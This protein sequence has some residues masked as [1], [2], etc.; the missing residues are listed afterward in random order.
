MPDNIWFE[1]AIWMGLAFIASLISIRVGISVALI[2]IFVGIVAGNFLGI[3]QTTQWID[4]LAMLGSVVLTFLAG[5]EIDPK[6]LKANIKISSTIGILSFAIP[7]AFIWMFAQFV[8]GWDI[9]QAQIAG[10]ALSTTSVA[11]IYAVLIEKEL[12]DTSLGKMLLASCFITDL[13]TVLALGALFAELSRLLAVFAAV[14][15]LVLWLMPRC[16]KHIIGKFGAKRVSEPE[17]KFILLIL[18]FMGGLATTAKS[19]AVLP[20]Y[21]IGL[22][23]AG[24]FLTDKT[25]VNRMRTIAFTIFTP[26][27]FIKA[28]LYVSLKA[29]YLSAGIIAVLLLF[30]IIL[31]T[32]GVWPAAYRFRMNRSMS[33]YTTLLMSTGLTFGTISALYGLNNH[34]IDQN[35]YTVLVAVVILSA[36]IPTLIA[37]RFFEPTVKEMNDWNRVELKKRD[38]INEGGGEE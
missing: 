18:F 22:V 17:V 32:I 37:Q 5:A 25:L 28:G 7:F 33:A 29:V 14:L 26:F 19:E 3:H 20:A 36:I 31:K 30:K 35:Q 12:A 23:V 9:R 8:L 10:I 6:S 21:L 13:G 15:I 4:F 24:V 1:A 2:E 34:I 38:A 16:T 27:Y 11:V